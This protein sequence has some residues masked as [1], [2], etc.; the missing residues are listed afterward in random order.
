MN[1][2][3]TAAI[4]LLAGTTVVAV[5]VWPGD[6]PLFWAIALAVPAAAIAAVGARAA[7]P[8]EPV[9]SAVPDEHGSATMP[10]AANLATR[11]AEAHQDPYRFRTRIQPR[12]RKL[13]EAH[14]HA[15]R[16]S[17]VDDPRAV[18]VLGAELHHLVTSPTAVLPPARRVVELLARLEES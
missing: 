16:I 2:L 3:K 6:I 17:T 7:G 13:A 5:G 10:Q 9:W 12:L 14:L 1:A 8:L 15:H 4:A 11:L 18:A